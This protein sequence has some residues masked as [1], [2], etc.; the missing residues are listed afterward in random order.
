MTDRE[1]PLRATPSIH[2]ISMPNF[3]LSTKLTTST[4]PSQAVAPLAIP[5]DQETHRGAV[6][7]HSYHDDVF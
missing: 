1:Q 7:K 4:C 2:L 5:F 3:Y 6:G